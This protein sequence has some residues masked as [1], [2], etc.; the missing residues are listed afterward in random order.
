MFYELVESLQ[1]KIGSE[2]LFFQ[3]YERNLD[4]VYKRLDQIYQKKLTDQSIDER[5]FLK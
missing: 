4:T 5:H 3:T 1:N 2:I